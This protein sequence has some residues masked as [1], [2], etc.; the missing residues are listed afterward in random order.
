MNWLLCLYEFICENPVLIFVSICSAHM[1]Q[2]FQVRI[3]SKP[4]Q[5]YIEVPSI[6]KYVYFV[7]SRF[8]Q[9]ESRAGRWY[10]SWSWLCE[11]AMHEELG[12]DCSFE[13]L[14]I[15]DSLRGVGARELAH[16]IEQL[17]PISS[18]NDLCGWCTWNLI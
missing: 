3:I 4:R 5:L 9:K 12:G 17:R 11:R 10:E 13:R 16:T 18:A 14:L 7:V 8:I 6:R 15:N 1:L 2:P